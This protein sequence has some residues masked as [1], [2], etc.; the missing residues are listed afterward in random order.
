MF[1]DVKTTEDICD[2]LMQKNPPIYFDHGTGFIRF[3][4]KGNLWLELFLPQYR[5]SP[6]TPG[7]IKSYGAH[8]YSTILLGSIFHTVFWLEDAPDGVFRLGKDSVVPCIQNVHFAQTYWD[9]EVLSGN[10]VKM[11][12]VGVLFQLTRSEQHM[13]E[14]DRVLYPEAGLK[15]YG[16]S[17]LPYEMVQE[18]FRYVRRI[19]RDPFAKKLLEN[20]L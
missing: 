1:N 20:L 12:P 17:P 18:M 3:P 13:D 14:V 4:L 9:T 2:L 19:G 16:D 11:E 8:L 15:A 6:H 5:P 10:F 7:S